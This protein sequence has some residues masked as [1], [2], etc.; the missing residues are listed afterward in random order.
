MHY[1]S[2]ATLA[3]FVLAAT[4]I[5]LAAP[6]VKRDVE[7]LDKRA[8]RFM[9]YTVTVTHTVWA[10][11]P[12]AKPTSTLTTKSE[13]VKPTTTSVVPQADATTTT[14]I[15]K[16]EEPVIPTTSTTSSP[17]PAQTSENP[18]AVVPAPAPVVITTTSTT[19]TPAPVAAPTT[20]SAAV[21]VTP[22]ATGSS[23]LSAF[24]QEYLNSHNAYRAKHGAPALKF[25]Q[26]LADYA[27][28]HVGNC[29][30]AH[31]SPYKYGENLAAGYATV[32][33]AIDAWYQEEVYYDYAK[34]EF[35]S[36]TGHFTQV[37]WAN[38][39]EIGC[40]SIACNG[41][42]GTPGTYYSCSYDQGNIS[43]Q[44]AANVKPPI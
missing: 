42:N 22:P 37:V 38:A 14:T 7:E 10:P 12:S 3:T 13:E 30:F 26:T 16:V 31:S 17:A 1:N 39:K 33:K 40:G 23:G 4:N 32:S 5:V 35:S 15:I 24:A 27:Q 11:Y 6:Q 29:V 34:A 18:V 28:A 41:K 9:R 43:G 2:F 21:V 44:F 8:L 19:T 36:Q 25:S 20:T